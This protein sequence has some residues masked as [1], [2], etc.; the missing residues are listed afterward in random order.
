V[1]GIVWIAEPEELEER[2]RVVGEQG[3]LMLSI[4]ADK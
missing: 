4:L 2:T 3:M 1:E